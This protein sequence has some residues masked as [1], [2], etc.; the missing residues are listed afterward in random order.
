MDPTQAAP[1]VQPIILE[2]ISLAKVMI[3]PTMIVVFFS[4]IILR[5]LIYYTVTR[6]ESF[7]KEF[8]KRV[9]RFLDGT[10]VHSSRSFFVLSKRILEKT[11]YE[12]FEIRSIMMRRKIDHI[13]VPSDRIFWFSPGRLTWS[14]IVSRS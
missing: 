3:I 1:T 2:L 12:M 6:E 10:D 8:E 4:S 13:M 11:Y 9:N 7:A 14:G 5:A